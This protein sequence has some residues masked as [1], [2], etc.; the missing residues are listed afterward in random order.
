[1]FVF[2][3]WTV[4]QR[5]EDDSARRLKSCRCAVQAG[6]GQGTCKSNIWAGDFW[7]LWKILLILCHDIYCLVVLLVYNVE[8]AKLP[9][10][11]PNIIVSTFLGAWRGTTTCQ[12][13]HLGLQ[14]ASGSS[15]TLFKMPLLWS[16]SCRVFFGFIH[17]WPTG[18]VLCWRMWKEQKRGQEC[19]SEGAK[20]VKNIVH[21]LRMLLG[22]LGF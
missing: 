11:K 21:M 6:K 17:C 18:K 3:N 1:M 7:M 14:L 5:V 4:F 19:I 2:A 22:M 10:Q 15:L 9:F 16:F 12:D 13:L 20:S 8:T